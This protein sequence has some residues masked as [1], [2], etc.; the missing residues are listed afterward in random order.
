MPGDQRRLLRHAG[1]AGD[2][3]DLDQIL[4]NIYRERG[5]PMVEESGEIA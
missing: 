4:A 3:S 2:D 1:A 5:H